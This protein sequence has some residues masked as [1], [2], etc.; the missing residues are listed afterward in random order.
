MEKWKWMMVKG[1]KPEIEVI[2]KAKIKRASEKASQTETRSLLYRKREGEFGEEILEIPKGE[3]AF[4]RILYPH[5]N[6]I[7]GKWFSKEEKVQAALEGISLIEEDLLYKNLI[8]LLKEEVLT[9]AEKNREKLGEFS[10]EEQR[11]VIPYLLQ[12]PSRKEVKAQILVNFFLREKI[13]EDD[14]ILFFQGRLSPKD[15]LLL[16][17]E[18]L[19]SPLERKE[20]R[21][22][23]LLLDI[24][25]KFEEGKPF[26][27][28]QNPKEVC[29]QI[30]SLQDLLKK[31]GR[32]EKV[33]IRGTD[34]SGSS[35]L[36][37]AHIR[38]IRNLVDAMK[39]GKDRELSLFYLEEK[40]R[41]Y[42]SLRY[43]VKKEDVF[44][45]LSGIEMVQCKDT[46]IF[47]S[48]NAISWKK[49]DSGFAED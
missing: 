1:E 15:F 21:K 48:L 28:L 27:F 44:A 31:E 45:Y 14:L 9:F 13:H 2:W 33:L 5:G 30:R 41:N 40:E 10:E 4:S 3:N 26:L 7:L 49:E 16:D 42:L 17:E 24:L 8:S 36:F 11:E 38:I 19:E 29:S 23:A 6:K 25:E 35:F 12:N 32:E 47:L 20:L 37:E 43:G 39:K 46:A 34:L 18:I 22:A